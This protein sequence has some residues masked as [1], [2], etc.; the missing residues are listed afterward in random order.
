VNYRQSYALHA[1]NGI[2]FNH[3]GPTRGETFV[4]RKITRAVAAIEYGIQRKLFIGNLDAK[5][6]WGH[7]KDFVEAMWLILQQPEPDDFVIATGE[8]HSV[9]EF[10][11][12]AFAKVGKDITWDGKGVDE[13]G[14]E[15][16]SGRVLIEV[17]PRYFRPTEVDCLVGDPSKARHKLGW[18]HKISF[19]A[20]ITEMV[21]ADL[22][23]V[24]KEIQTSK[25]SRRIRKRESGRKV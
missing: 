14:I 13:K 3:E 9:R 12:L 8:S 7:A 21:E 5:R 19:E 1:S 23:A 2:L 10:L 4:T 22:S 6:D 15:K 11:E 20:L 18:Q 25:G 16:G 17:D 24:H